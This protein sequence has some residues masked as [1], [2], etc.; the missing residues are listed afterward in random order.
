MPPRLAPWISDGWVFQ[1]LVKGVLRRV[2]L[3]YGPALQ[4][5][6]LEQARGCPRI[7]QL[8]PGQS[9]EMNWEPGP[10]GQGLGAGAVCDK[11]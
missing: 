2:F 6:W 3:G 4:W 9:L 11:G 8:W 10:V 7:D 5:M 1:T